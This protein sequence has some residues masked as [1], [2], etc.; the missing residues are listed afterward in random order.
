M[1]STSEDFGQ[2]AKSGKTPRLKIPKRPPAIPAK[3]PA[4]MN[5]SSSW[6]RTST[7]MNSVR[8]GFS[9][10]VVRSRPNGDRTTRRRIH[11]HAATS[12]TVST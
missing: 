6:R 8:S 1:M 4:M 12:P 5:A 9:R 7:P 2:Y 3:S 11:R 10:I